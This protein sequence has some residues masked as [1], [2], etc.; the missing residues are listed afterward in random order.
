MTLY[1]GYNGAQNPQVDFLTRS[2]CRE[3][4]NTVSMVALRA[5]RVSTTANK[6]SVIRL[7]RLFRFLPFSSF[8]FFFF[9]DRNIFTTTR[10]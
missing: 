9:T 1:E 8:F 7:F 6:Q 2:T 10:V 5:K 3:K 4:G